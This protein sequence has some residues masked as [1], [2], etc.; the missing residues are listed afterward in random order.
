MTAQTQL[1]LSVRALIL[2]PDNRVLLVQRARN[3][4]K[5]FPGTWELPGGKIQ[6]NGDL[7]EDMR[8]EL[9]EETGIELPQDEHI[10]IVGYSHFQ[11]QNGLWITTILFGAL[12]TF[13][14]DVTLSKEHDAF[15]WVA[16][17]DVWKK[18]LAPGNTDLFERWTEWGRAFRKNVEQ[19]IRDANR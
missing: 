1:G 6:Q 9:L 10:P 8:R 19:I 13:I 18:D 5:F 16:Y 3:D 4:E 11:H 14:P 17:H 2:R 7:L 12:V 15:E